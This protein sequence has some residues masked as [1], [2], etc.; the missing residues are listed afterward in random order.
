MANGADQN[1]FAMVPLWV[2]QAPGVTPTILS[3]YVALA[4]YG[5]D[6]GK[7]TVALIEATGIRKSAVYAGIQVL[8]GVGALVREPDGSLSCPSDWTELALPVLHPGPHFVYRLWSDDVLVYIGVTSHI[9]RRLKA[10]RRRWGDRITRIEKTE[11]PTRALAN[12]AEHLAIANEWPLTN[13][14][15]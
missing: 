2:Y 12:K 15:T 3:M 6:A 9:E 4:M 14:A 7:S 5:W 10:H 1:P 11:Y 8:I 13:V